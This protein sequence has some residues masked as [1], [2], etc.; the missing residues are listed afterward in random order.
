MIADLQR[1]QGDLRLL[2]T[3]VARALLAAPWPA[4]LAYTAWGATPRV[5]PMNFVWT[6][7]ELVIGPAPVLDALRTGA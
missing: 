4:H 6:G 5:T 1:P 3:D 7:E 2:N